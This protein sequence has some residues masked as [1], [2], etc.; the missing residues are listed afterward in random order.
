MDEDTHTR[1]HPDES[2]V[3]DDGRARRVVENTRALV[4]HP[5]M[6]TTT[7]GVDPQ[8]VL[9]PKVLCVGGG[10]CACACAC[11]GVGARMCVCIEG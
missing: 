2:E 9:E 1:T 7:A 8:P 5:A 11:V 6:H 4:A 3:F 10:A